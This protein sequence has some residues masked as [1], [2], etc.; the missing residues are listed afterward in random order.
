MSTDYGFMTHL[1]K[2]AQVNDFVRNYLLITLRAR[3][4]FDFKV[5]YEPQS[6]S[7]KIIIHL[8]I[9]DV[10]CSAG[11]DCISESCDGLALTKAIEEILRKC[12]EDYAKRT[13]DYF[14]RMVYRSR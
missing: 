3:T 6:L 5:I 12:R 14:N 11:M 8:N 4:N 10:H 1:E 7:F 13:G 9:D 2:E